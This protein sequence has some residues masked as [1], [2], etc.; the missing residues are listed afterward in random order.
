MGTKG[1]KE[2]KWEE[3]NER[4]ERGRDREDKSYA[5]IRKKEGRKKEMKKR[6]RICK[7]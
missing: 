6:N 2:R 7:R 4:T 3:G 1:K 5:Y